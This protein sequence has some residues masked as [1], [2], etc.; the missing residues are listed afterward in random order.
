MKRQFALFQVLAIAA[1]PAAAAAQDLPGDAV[2]G[3]EFALRYCSDCHVIAEGQ[4]HP[5]T[6]GAPP[7]ASVARMKGVARLS[8]HAF[9]QTPHRRMP[10]LIL[11]RMAI[12]DVVAYILSL[13]PAKPPQKGEKS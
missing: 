4:P 11:D 9:L 7:F 5:A 12:D 6:D 2:A 13:R 10:N 3:R 1:S 8:L